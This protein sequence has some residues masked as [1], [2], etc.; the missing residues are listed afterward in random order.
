MGTCPWRSSFVFQIVWKSTA[1]HCALRPVKEL[2]NLY[3]LESSSF[4]WKFLFLGWRGKH[5]IQ[6]SHFVSPFLLPRSLSPPS[7]RLSFDRGP[8]RPEISHTA[9]I[10]PFDVGQTSKALII[11]AAR[12]H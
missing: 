9:N 3:E 6:I 2:W 5:K 4:Y 1:K 10:I 8:K 7:L 12:R 11:E